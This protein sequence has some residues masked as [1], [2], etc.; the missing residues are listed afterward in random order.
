[1]GLVGGVGF[2]WVELVM[3][4][5]GGGSLSWLVGE[6][7]C[8]GLAVAWWF[9][10]SGLCRAVVGVGGCVGRGGGVDWFGG[11]CSVEVGVGGAAEVGW[12]MN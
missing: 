6:V 7:G 8:W 12:G 2:G 3:V 4:G 1:M 11:V 9:R 10:G 5:C